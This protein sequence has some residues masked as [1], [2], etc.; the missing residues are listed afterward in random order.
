[1]GYHRSMAKA[2]VGKRGELA[3]TIDSSMR[4]VILRGPDLFQR[5][6]L[7]A[8]VGDG[9]HK[10]QP[11]LG[12]HGGTHRFR[13]RRVSLIWV[14]GGPIV[15]LADLP[16]HSSSASMCPRRAKT[17]ITYRVPSAQSRRRV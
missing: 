2:S 15:R 14:P 12:P 16:A 7:S 3:E 1:M 11:G 4:V 17:L 5:G 10:H 8:R 6:Y 13:V 9:L